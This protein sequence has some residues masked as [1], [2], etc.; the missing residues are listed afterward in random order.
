MLVRISG[1]LTAMFCGYGC[2]WSIRWAVADYDVRNLSQSTIEHALRL[3]P[4]N[5]DYYSRLALAEP[6]LALSALQRAADLNPLDSSAWI[7]LAGAAEEHAEF[8]RAESALLRA[9]DLDKTFAPRW[10]LAEYYSRR[11][12]QAHF[13]PAV[14]AALATSYDDVTPLF[15][16]CWDLA[17]EPGI[18][19]DRALPSRP[20]IW[21]QYFDFL[22]AKNRLAAADA[23]ANQLMQHVGRDTVPSLLLYCDRLLEK[24]QVSRA[25]ETWN[26]LAA[27]RLLDY[28]SLA[29]RQGASLTNGN[30]A[31]ALLSSAFDWRVST[32]E[33]IL[34]RR[35]VSPPGLRFDFSGKQPEHCELLSQFVPVEAAREY[36]LV[37]NYETEDLE[38]DPGIGWRIVDVKS[39]TD[40]LRG[41]G[42]MTASEREE[43]AEAYKFHT[44]AD[45][46]LVKLVLAYD[47]PLGAVRVEGSLS[48]RNT[49]LGFDQ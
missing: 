4:G 26:L 30:F 17:P 39:G 19:V 47:R 8:R 6:Q 13:W 18:I 23:I 20:D 3:A 16:M 33:E 15:E 11:H 29:P 44:P 27:K 22:L 40:L 10:L 5:P 48:L 1:A 38:G 49:A 32:P 31:K 46:R 41:A 21:R 2:Y 24:N 28:P 34:Y 37:V 42:H 35:D 14:R 9:V 12:D 45:A 25:L 7:E 36:K 43:K